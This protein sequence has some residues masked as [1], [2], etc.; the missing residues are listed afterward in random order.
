MQSA[1]DTVLFIASFAGVNY[2]FNR[3]LTLYEKATGMKVNTGQQNG[4][5]SH[6][7]AKELKGPPKD[8]AWC[9]KGEWIISLGVPIGNTFDE[10]AR[11][12]EA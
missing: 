1:D 10:R 2:M 3:V 7:S 4:Q 8:V 9:K 5:F 6:G 11:V 12:L